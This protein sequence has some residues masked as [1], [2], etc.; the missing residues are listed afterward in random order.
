MKL[1]DSFQFV[2]KPIYMDGRT[3]PIRVYDCPGI[4]ETI[5][6]EELEFL[7][8]GYIKNGSEVP[9]RKEINIFLLKYVLNVHMYKLNR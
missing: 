6:S 9:V 4:S 5:G 1:H 8:K 2:S 7:I 3:L